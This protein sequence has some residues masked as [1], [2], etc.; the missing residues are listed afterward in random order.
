MHGQD[1]T[2]Q[3][4][5]VPIRYTLSNVQR[6]KRFGIIFGTIRISYRPTMQQDIFIQ[7][8]TLDADLMKPFLFQATRPC[9]VHHSLL[10]T[11]HIW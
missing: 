9:L 1:T 11:V 2:K 7:P 10:C 6:G 4:V 3:S 5:I 8:Q